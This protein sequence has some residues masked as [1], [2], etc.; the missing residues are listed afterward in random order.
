MNLTELEP[1]FLKVESP[2]SYRHVSEIAQ[3]DGICFLCPKCFVKNAG[4]V[5]THSMICWQP[6][7]PQTVF[8]TPGRWKFVGTGYADLSLDNH[9]GASSV[10]D[11]GGCG[12]HFHIRA[13]VIEMC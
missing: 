8:P 5:G 6:H 1:Q 12:C 4:P 7:V 3:A 13:G 10:L 9:P 11:E 2:S